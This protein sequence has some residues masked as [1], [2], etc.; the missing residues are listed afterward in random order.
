[1]NILHTYI[2]MYIFVLCSLER[3]RERERERVRKQQR[4]LKAPISIWVGH[5]ALLLSCIA[6]KPP[7]LHSSLRLTIPTCLHSLIYEQDLVKGS[8]EEIKA[9]ETH[10]NLNERIC[11][12]I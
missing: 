8:G 1:M 10:T 6:G 3:E 9:S 11:I 4:E 12:E 7:L 2:C 5:Q